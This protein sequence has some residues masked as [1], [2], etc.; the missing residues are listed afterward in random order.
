[1]DSDTL[2]SRTGGKINLFLWPA[3]FTQ[4][5]VLKV[6]PSCKV[7]EPLSFPRLSNTLLYVRTTPRVSTSRCLC[8]TREPHCEC[9]P[10]S[11]SALC[12]NHTVSVHHPLTALGENHTVSV[13]QLLTDTRGASAF[14]L[15]WTVA[16]RTWCTNICSCSWFR[17]FCK[18]IPEWNDRII[19]ISR[20]IFWWTTKT[21]PTVAATFYTPKSHV[22]GSNFSMSSLMLIFFFK[23]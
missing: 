1:M 16:P 6:H 17:Y 8:S 11:D 22:K 3:C 18:Y 15:S 2:G 4:P 7:C 21:F 20:L 23:E 10:S 14:W 9:P 5:N 19:G 13:H 12:E